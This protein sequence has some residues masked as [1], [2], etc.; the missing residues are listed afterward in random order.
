MP[1]LYLS[2]APLNM[3]FMQ[4][5]R[6]GLRSLRQVPHL[7]TSKKMLRTSLDLNQLLFTLIILHKSHV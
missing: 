3:R 6:A 7:S 1:T 4:I 2:K 5:I